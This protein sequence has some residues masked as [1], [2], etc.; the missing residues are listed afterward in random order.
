LLA[1]Y[2]LI[3]SSGSLLGPEDSI[4]SG[5]CTPMRLCAKN[6][7]SQWAPRDSLPSKGLRDL[8]GPRNGRF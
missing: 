7:P 1:P 5:R 3:T 8:D 4:A 2:V 6:G